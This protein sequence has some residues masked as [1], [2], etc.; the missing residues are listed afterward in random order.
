MECD[1][2]STKKSS[3]LSRNP[4]SRQ[5]APVFPQSEKTP[6]IVSQ[7][8]AV[9]SSRSKFLKQTP[10]SRSPSPGTKMNLMEDDSHMNPSACSIITISSESEEDKHNNLRQN[11]SGKK[12]GRNNHTSNLVGA[13]SPSIIQST[14]GGRPM[15]SSVEDAPPLF[16]PLAEQMQTSSQ[17][18]VL[19][20]NSEIE[21]GQS[22]GLGNLSAKNRLKD[23]FSGSKSRQIT[24]QGFSGQNFR[25]ESRTGF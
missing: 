18:S 15:V 19:R 7:P 3:R 21:V 22:T 5:F 12:S 2:K 13:N 10:C 23:R 17:A 8:G 24:G 20:Q 1:A 4:S 6:V 25:Q 11:G 16:L 14:T 9:G